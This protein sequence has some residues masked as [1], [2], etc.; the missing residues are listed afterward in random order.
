[1]ADFVTGH[2]HDTRYYLKSP[3]DATFYNTGFMGSG[4]GADADLLDGHHASE[5][6]AAGLPVGMIVW[7]SGT[8]GTIP[9]GW[10]ACNGQTDTTDYRDYFVVGAGS[11]YSVKGTLGS[12]SVTPTGTVT[13]GGTTLDDTQIPAHTHT[14]TDVYSVYDAGPYDYTDGQAG[15][16]YNPTTNSRTS[17][18]SGSSN[19]H[20]H[21]TGS[22]VTYNSESNI[23]PYYA[24][25]L[26][27]K[28]S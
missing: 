17:N 14:F 22:S 20:D 9:T 26:I 12:S 7:W 3:S 24:L 11:T 21:S 19:A 10:K 28:V 27:K 15:G 5:A 16:S 2:N 13:I 8:A 1:M 6:I 23:P 18:A 25:Y 4:S